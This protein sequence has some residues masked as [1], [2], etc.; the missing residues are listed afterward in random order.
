MGAV[1]Q[2]ERA[3]VRLSCTGCGA[4]ANASCDCHKPY[5]PAAAKA[6][7]AIAANPNK[8]DR[9]IAAEIGVAPN[10]VRTARQATAQDCAVDERV[11]LD[12]KTRKLPQ[13]APRGF[14][15]IPEG[16][17]EPTA[18]DHENSLLLRAATAREL[19]E[20]EFHGRPTDELVDAA[21]ATA[22]AWENLAHQLLEQK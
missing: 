5:V 16:D 11:G 19:A 6:A 18:E 3:I 20:I 15:A 13:R 8:S 10:T 12:G 9:A 4:E 2:I 14:Y 7:A 22:A 17:A 21:R 1:Y